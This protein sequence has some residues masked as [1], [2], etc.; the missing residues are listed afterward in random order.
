MTDILLS[1]IRQEFLAA[2]ARD[3]LSAEND[4]LSEGIVD[5][6]GIMRLIAF[7]ESE[8]STAV[9]PEDVTIENFINVQAISNYLSRSR[10]DQA[11]IPT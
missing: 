9:P 6:L 8:F 7:I 1:F 3:A 4:L 5:S 2:S 11:D 10:P